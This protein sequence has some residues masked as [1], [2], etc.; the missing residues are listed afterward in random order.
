MEVSL[1][2][3][4]LNNQIMVV[5]TGL[6]GEAYRLISI[7]QS[8][9]IIKRSLK[10]HKRIEQAIQRDEEGKLNR[11]YRKRLKFYL[12][13]LGEY[14][15]S[16]VFKDEIEDSLNVA[17]G[18]AIRF[19]CDVNIRLVVSTDFLNIVPWELFYADGAFLCHVY[20]LYRHPFSLQPVK[21]QARNMDNLSVLFVGANPNS[22]I[23]IRG[24]IDA[25][26]A[27]IPPDKKDAF[28]LLVTPDA[29]VTKIASRIFAGTDILH[30]LAHGRYENQSK[31]IKSYFVVDG[32]SGKGPNR[33]SSE[34]LQSFCR[35]N[36]MKLAILGACR[37]DQA[38]DYQSVQEEVILNGDYFSTA[39]AL[40]KTG[41]PCVVGMSHPVSKIATEMLSRRLYI[42]L[43]QQGQSI[44]RAMRQARLELFA[45]NDTLLPSD[46]FAPVLYSR[47]LFYSKKGD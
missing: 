41:I 23:Y 10:L 6:S 37:S 30:M 17:I 4:Y 9:K 40:I 2:L 11:N 39:H 38:F 26:C 35:A 43:L 47:G 18:Q 34:M 8:E 1:Q 25:V 46:W 15:Y 24:Q 22:D 3:R 13:H 16:V 21:Q 45:H 7:F 36:P 28:N 32:E 14:L 31:N 12:K 44:A 20:D 42:G 19:N 27:G 29:T 33:L 5:S